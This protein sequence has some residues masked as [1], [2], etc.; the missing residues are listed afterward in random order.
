MARGF[1]TLFVLLFYASPLLAVEVTF[2]LQG[3]YRPGRYLP[4]RV[5]AAEN[6][7]IDA[8]IEV[9]VNAPIPTRIDL[10]KG[11][12]DSVVPLL[13]GRAMDQAFWEIKSASGR[14]AG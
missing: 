6:M 1:A 5:R 8:T 4:V 12:V 2:P 7:P 3:F 14:N 11:Q 13:A 9:N 10:A